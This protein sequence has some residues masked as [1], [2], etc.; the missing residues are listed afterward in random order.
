MD[1]RA[2]RSKAILA[3]R[4]GRL[5]EA[6]K[7]YRHILTI[8]KDGAI[9]ANLGAVL[10]ELRK[11]IEARD[12]YLWALKECT[13]HQTLIINATNCFLEIGDLERCR[14]FLEKG[15]NI[16]PGDKNIQ[17]GLARYYLNTNKPKDALYILAEIVKSDSPP[18]GYWRTLG[19]TLQQLNQKDKAIE[20]YEKAL[21][22]NPNDARSAGQLLI[23]LKEKGEISKAYEKYES[24][25]QKMR[26]MPEIMSAKAAILLASQKVNEACQIYQSLCRSENTNGDHWLNLAYCQRELKQIIAPWES[27]K[28]GLKNEPAHKGLQI[29]MVQIS[30][31]LGSKIQSSTLL[32]NWL[33]KYRDLSD[34]E[35]RSVQFIGAGYKL[36]NSEKLKEIAKEWERKKIGQGPRNIHADYICTNREPR[37][38]RVCYLSGDLCRHPVGRF[39]LAI[40]KKH[41]RDRVWILGAHT[42]S[43]ND[44]VTK[45]TRENCD[46]WLDLTNCNDLQGARMIADQQIDVLIELGG[47]TGGGRPGILVHKPANIQL[48][49]LGYFAPT[50]LK[51]I[52]GWIGDSILFN[53]LDSTDSQIEQILIPGGYM[54]LP[55]GTSWPKIEA[56]SKRKFRFGCFNNTRKLTD[57]T[58]R[59]FA[60]ILKEVPD[61]QLAI[62]SI[63][64]VENSEKERIFKRL[65]DA[66][67]EKGKILILPWSANDKE[68][69]ESYKEID[70]AL[71]TTPYSGATTTCE[72]LRMGVP[73]V[74]MTGQ[75][76]A[77]SLSASVLYFSN[78]KIW[79]AKNENE[80]IDKAIKLSTLGVRNKKSR[81]RLS[82]RVKQSAFGD[83]LRLARE[84]EDCLIKLTRKKRSS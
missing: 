49:Y 19:I 57:E 58:L 32:K 66:G 38:I 30:A 68:H 63:S 46:S 47:Y 22:E 73:V 14:E 72:A 41:N 4:K 81:R 61:G 18:T 51:C 55:E 28:S 26:D 7:L 53:S 64:F 13:M 34:S 29:A 31:D 16:Y 67:I 6:E 11:Y 40:I 27:V 78:N 77:G 45:E 50:Y 10:K 12:F 69:L 83:A 20:A 80:Y 76:M 21:Q 59:L 39:I 79:I 56:V 70:V 65:V 75:G 48:S 82:L 17:Q 5:E 15:C 36:L 44:E 8:Q 54:A 60:M 25:T 33:G 37:K 2:V 42:G 24:F 84:I 3:H 52:D 71:D 23:Q 9:A 74:T 35:H 1:T 43:I 62:K